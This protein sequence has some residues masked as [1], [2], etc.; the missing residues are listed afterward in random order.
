MSSDEQHEPME[1]SMADAWPAPEWTSAGHV[2]E[3]TVHAWLD[4]ALNAEGANAVSAHVAACAACGALTAEVR[5]VIAGAARVVALLDGAGATVRAEGGGAGGGTRTPPR[6]WYR[7]PTVPSPTSTAPKPSSPRA[8]TP[9]R[10]NSSWK[11][12]QTSCCAARTSN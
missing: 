7:R 2:T 5:G 12:T 3:P 1:A 4:G 9:W 11:T 10:S 8:V 6:A